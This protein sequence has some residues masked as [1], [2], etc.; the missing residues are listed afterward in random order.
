MHRVGY[1]HEV[2]DSSTGCLRRRRPSR[3]V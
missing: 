3:R 1:S 2:D